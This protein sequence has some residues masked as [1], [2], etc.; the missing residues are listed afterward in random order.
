MRG[1]KNW[2]LAEIHFVLIDFEALVC[3]EDREALGLP[4]FSTLISHDIIILIFSLGF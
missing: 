4:L 2:I 1:S 3:I